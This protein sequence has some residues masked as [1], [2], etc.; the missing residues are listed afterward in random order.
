MEKERHP[1]RGNDI[2]FTAPRKK[3]RLNR[4]TIQKKTVNPLSL[5]NGEDRPVKSGSRAR[6]NISAGPPVG[7]DSDTPKV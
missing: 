4:G 2:K 5:L 1:D 7:A 3:K 6:E